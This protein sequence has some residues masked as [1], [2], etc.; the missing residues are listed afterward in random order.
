M[1]WRGNAK[2]MQPTMWKYSQFEENILDCAFYLM[3]NIAKINYKSWYDPV[4]ISRGLS[5]AVNANDDNGVLMG[6]WSD[7][8]ADGVS[9]TEWLGSQKILQKYWRD[10]KP[11]K[12]GQC[13]VFAGV[14]ATVCRALGLPCRVVTN[15]K[16]AHDTHGNL[17]LDFY[18]DTDGNHV[19][20]KN[21]DT[22]W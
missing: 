16:S 2:Q 5:A 11:V 18:Y 6:N 9:P 15:Y 13:W 1:I 19:K 3:T 14:F 21:T 17:T 12:Y 8:Y 7:D 22:I 10:K 4:E 20:D